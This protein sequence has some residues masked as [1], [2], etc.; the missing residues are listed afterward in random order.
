MYQMEQF[1]KPVIAA[2]QLLYCIGGGTHATCQ[3]QNGDNSVWVSGRAAAKKSENEVNRIASKIS[4]VI[5]INSV[6]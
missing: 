2:I 6:V 1:I 5:Y 3:S 4:V